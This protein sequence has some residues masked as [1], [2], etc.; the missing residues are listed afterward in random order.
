[1]PSQQRG[2]KS[3]FVGADR[4]ETQLLLVSVVL[5]FV[6][7]VI[8]TTFCSAAVR[9]SGN[10]LSRAKYGGGGGG[11]AALCSWCKGNRPLPAS[12]S[13]TEMW[14]RCLFFWMKRSTASCQR[15]TRPPAANRMIVA[16][17]SREV[18]DQ[19][20]CDFQLPIRAPHFLKLLSDRTHLEV[21][22]QMTFHACSLVNFLGHTQKTASRMSPLE[23]RRDRRH[24]VYVLD[25]R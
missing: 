12:G 11:G 17:T 20:R 5:L 3:P 18:L 10:K 22:G 8:N 13:A 16:L 25:S 4:A 9:L 15:H 21:R 14:W 2:E 7:S 6:F 1:M 19:R 24:F 23:R